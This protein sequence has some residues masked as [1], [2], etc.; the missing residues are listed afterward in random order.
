MYFKTGEYVK[1]QALFP[2]KVDLRL[3]KMKKTFEKKFSFFSRAPS[4]L[5]V[6]RSLVWRRIE[7]FSQH[8]DFCSTKKHNAIIKVIIEAISKVFKNV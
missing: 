8:S 3:G 1:K 5:L 2:I 6:L 4:S 7:T